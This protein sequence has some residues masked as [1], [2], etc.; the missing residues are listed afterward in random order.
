MAH[1]VGTIFAE[2]DLDFEPYTRAQKKLVKDAT[3]STLNIEKS[4]KDL[5][6]K[7]AKEFDLMR[8]KV[9]NSY[10]R[11]TKDAKTSAADIVR[12]SKARACHVGLPHPLHPS[13]NDLAVDS[14][15]KASC[16]FRSID[17]SSL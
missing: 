10:N 16:T 3:S 6:I 2:V 12:A 11:I 4:Y 15:S 9:S 7:S 5:G 1:K 8:A 17:S 14:R 13:P